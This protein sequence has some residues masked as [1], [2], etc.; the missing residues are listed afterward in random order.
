MIVTAETLANPHA[1]SMIDRKPGQHHCFYCDE[2][3]TLP[4]VHW[5]GVPKDGSEDP[6][7][8]FAD[9]QIALHPGCAEKLGACLISDGSQAQGK[10]GVPT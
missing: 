5:A 6:K 2:P 4:F 7:L 9:G 10:T 8:H 3:L 1:A